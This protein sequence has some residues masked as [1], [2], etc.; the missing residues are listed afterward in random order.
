MWLK[1]SDFLGVVV[2]RV[3]VRPSNFLG[4]VV[5]RV[6]VRP[7]DFMGAVV[8]RVWVI[9]W[10]SGR[11][12]ENGVGRTQWL[13]GVVAK[14][15]GETQ[16]LCRRNGEKG[17]VKTQRLPGRCGEKGVGWIQW[18]SGV[19]AKI[20]GETQWLCRRSGEKGVGDMRWIS[21][22]S[23]EKSVGETQWL[24]GRTG[25][26]TISLHC[27]VSGPGTPVLRQLLAKSRRLRQYHHEFCMRVKHG[28]N[29]KHR[30]T[31]TKG[32]W[33]HGLKAGA[34]CKARSLV[35]ANSHITCRAHTVPLPCRVDK[36]LDCVFPIWFT[37]CGRVWFTHAVLRPCRS[38][39]DFSRPRHST[40]WHVWI[41]IDRRKTA[42]G[43]PTRVR[44]FPATIRSFT[45]VVIRISNWNAAGQCEPKQRFSWTRIS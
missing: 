12:G 35:K 42:C 40:A 3:W 4:V 26:E 41:N 7:S 32:I 17:V 18:L 21:G 23:G 34:S 36:G 19:V 6:R 25:E 10:L 2:K 37:Q 14:S 43:R 9:Q 15:V 31:R 22:R 16:W 24:S 27:L 13:S 33:Q 29:R 45:T 38:Q 1:P 11:C 20:V 28:L 5:R 44:L 39:S 8:K 30:R